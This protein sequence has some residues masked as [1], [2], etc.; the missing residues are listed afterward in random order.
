M[1]NEKK[2]EINDL[3]QERSIGYN[4]EL[5]TKQFQKIN[6]SMAIINRNIF[7]NFSYISD[8]LSKHI[9][10]IIPKLSFTNYFSDLIAPLNKIFKDFSIQ[11]IK[12]I[13]TEWTD[14]LLS[15]LRVVRKNYLKKL[16]KTYSILKIQLYICKN[17]KEKRLILLSQ[18]ILYLS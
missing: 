3:D 18:F 17:D 6:Q 5:L 2:E 1:S 12:L 14:K 4:S 9:V 15:D 13:P 10:G 16:I 8:I 11:L 7:G